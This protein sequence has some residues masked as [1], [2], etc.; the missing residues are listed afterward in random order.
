MNWLW[1]LA[2]WLPILGIVL[3]ILD[4]V[5]VY[6]IRRRRAR[7]ERVHT[8]CQGFREVGVFSNI[9]CPKR[10][11]HISFGYHWCGDLDCRMPDDNR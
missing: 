4:A 11:K 6:G 3:T 10:A 7:M 9:R 5:R 1:L 8:V 2:L